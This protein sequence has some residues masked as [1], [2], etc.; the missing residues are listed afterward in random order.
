[1]EQQFIVLYAFY[2]YYKY[3]SNINWNSS[4][5]A[6]IYCCEMKFIVSIKSRP[7]LLHLM[8]LDE[9]LLVVRQLDAVDIFE[10]QNNR[11]IKSNAAVREFSLAEQ[12]WMQRIVG[13]GRGGDGGVGGHHQWDFWT[14]TSGFVHLQRN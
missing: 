2:C 8:S 14:N 6:T 12:H 7:Q 13:Q 9:F 5:G 1:V 10:H 11:Q 3:T 4:S